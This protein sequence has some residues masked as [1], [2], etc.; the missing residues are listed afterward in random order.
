MKHLLLLLVLAVPAG[1]SASEDAAFGKNINKTYYS[2]DNLEAAFKGG[3]LTTKNVEEY[4]DNA[5]IN[6]NAFQGFLREGFSKA[7]LTKAEEVIDTIKEASEEEKENVLAGL[8]LVK[9]GDVGNQIYQRSV[10]TFIK[11]LKSA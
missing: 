11:Q 2:L 7:V 9:A 6:W 1:I 3:T 4:L 10:R 8:L 5:S